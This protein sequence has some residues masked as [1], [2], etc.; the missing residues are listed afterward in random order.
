MELSLNFELT[1]GYKSESQKVRVL[2]ERWAND[3]IYCPNCG[4]Q[5]VKYKNNKPVADFYCLN[6]F[7]DYEL[8]SKKNSVGT[9]IVDGAYSTMVERLNSSKNPNFFILNYSS[10]SNSI[11][12]FFVIPKHYFVPEIIEKRSPLAENARR[13]G[14]VGCNILLQSIPKAGKIYLIKD[15][16]VR[17]KNLVMTEWQKTLFLREQTD[18][19]WLIDILRCIETFRGREFTLNEMY[20]FEEELSNR[21]P[22]NR[23]IRDKIRQQLQFLRD[24]DYITFIDRGKYKLVCDQN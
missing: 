8:K 19:G 24:K 10:H 2:T 1:E 15:G 21:H 7:E 4:E 11:T 9:K 5:I 18:A 13:A 16:I 22:N 12:N 14:W 23:H 3:N 17:P 6:C 20:K